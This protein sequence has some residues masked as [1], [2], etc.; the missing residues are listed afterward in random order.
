[1]IPANRFPVS[2]RDH[3]NGFVNGAEWFRGLCSMKQLHGF[4]I[5]AIRV[6][7]ACLLCKAQRGQAEYDRLAALCINAGRSN[8]SKALSAKIV[9]RFDA[10][11]R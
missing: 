8:P 6:G 5:T 2:S 10:A 3:E 4:A 9:P 11:R 7:T 1:L